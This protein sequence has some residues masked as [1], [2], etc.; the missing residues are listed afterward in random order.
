MLWKPRWLLALP[1]A[2]TLAATA[3]PTGSARASTIRDDAGMF[4]APAVQQAEAELNRIEREQQMPTT[5]E[6]VKSLDGGTVEAVTREHAGRSGSEGLYILIAKAEHK[7]D[8]HVSASFGGAMDNARRLAIRQAFISG[9]K[10]QDFDGALMAGVREVNTEISAAHA[11]NGLR[12]EAG[13]PGGAPVVRRGNPGGF[14]LGSLLGLGLV[15]VGVLFVFRLLGSLFRGG[16]GGYAP[17]PGG[18]MGRPGYGGA[19][20]GGFMSS[21]FGGIGGAM[22]GNWLYDQFSGRHQGGY[23]DSS[24]YG[25]DAGISDAGSAGDTSG[26]WGGGG[27]DL[28]GGGDWGGGGGDTGGGGDW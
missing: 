3:E 27:G 13:R 9:L 21:L 4:S 26:D 11:R 7:I 15:I 20:G 14:G 28:G 16:G 25:G 23:T 6:T 17:G 5:V 12:R 18:M 1:V 8:V 2:L 24:N 22:A 10:Q 19:G